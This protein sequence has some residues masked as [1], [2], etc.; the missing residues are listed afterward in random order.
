MKHYGTMLLDVIGCYWNQT[1]YAIARRV[2]CWGLFRTWTHR[3]ERF[4]GDL[5]RCTRLKLALLR[6]CESLAEWLPEHARTLIT[7]HYDVFSCKQISIPC[8]ISF[9]VFLGDL[10]SLFFDVI[11]CHLMS[12]DVIWCLCLWQCSQN[13]SRN[14]SP[15]SSQC[16]TCA[17]HNL[18]AAPSG[19]VKSFKSLKSQCNSGFWTEREGKCPKGTEKGKR[20]RGKHESQVD[21]IYGLYIFRI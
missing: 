9:L 6:R 10:W 3:I 14:S 1:M 18:A 11:W 4:D 17:G 7:S 19:T 8:W 5:M 2:Q 16:H 15:N 12:F 20:C 13:S 21:Y